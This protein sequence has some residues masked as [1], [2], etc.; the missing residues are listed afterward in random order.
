MQSPADRRAPPEPA[1]DADAIRRVREHEQQSLLDQLSDWLEIP[2]LVLALVWLGLFVVEI[3]WG[4]TPLLRTIGQVIWAIFAFDFLLELVIAPNKRRYLV[5]NW[6]K[7]LALLA[8][9]L[10]LLRVVRVLRLARLA[11]ATRGARLLRV[12]SSLNRGL[13]ALRA[14]MGRRRLG[15]VLVSTLLVLLAGA[16]GMLAF[17]NEQPGGPA[18]PS[19]GV[20]LWWTAMLMT[21]LGS[22]YWPQ[23]PEGRILCLLLSVYGFAVFGYLTATL[24]TF[25][26]G[27]DAASEQSDIAGERAIDALREEIAALRAE[28]R[29]RE[30]KPGH[31]PPA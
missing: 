24:A 9:A 28:L 2:M 20:A 21:T 23:T 27:Q 18:F 14:S 30:A 5:G 22:D 4:L 11:G 31:G 1:A 19:Y 26:I 29:E 7:A 6:L 16:A 12:V 15:F 10:R 17:E 13:R 3:V 8:P 25:F